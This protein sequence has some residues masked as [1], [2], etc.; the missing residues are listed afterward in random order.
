M[1]LSK[2]LGTDAKV[3]NILGL[4]VINCLRSNATSNLPEAIFERLKTSRA[5]L[6]FT[7]LQRLIELKS[8]DGTLKNI[9][10][11]AWDTLHAHETDV[12]LGLT[13]ESVDYFR[14]LLKIICLSLHA[15]APAMESSNADTPRDP[16]AYPSVIQQVLQVLGVVVARGFHSLTTMLHDDPTRVFPA[17]FALI[18]AILRISL[19]VPGILTHI[20]QLVIQFSDNQTARCACALLSWADKLAID[21]DPVYGEI[22]ISFLLELSSIQALAESLAVEGVLTH[23]SNANLINYLRHDKGIGPFD[24]PPRLYSIWSRGILPLLLNLLHAVGAP[25]AVEIATSLSNFAGQLARASRA[26]ESPSI[27][28][29]NPRA[30]AITLSTVSEAQTLAVITTVLNTFREAGPSVGINASEINEIGWDM[31]QVRDDIENLLQ[32]RSVLRDR[33]FPVN[34]RE[35]AWVRQPPLSTA[36]GAENRL[37]EKVVGELTTVLGILGGCGQ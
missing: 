11:T 5:D 26:F 23:I 4:T 32:R 17:D 27:V 29:T 16:S 30:G 35:E 28:S 3:Q 22:S 37:E 13:G 1:E 25:M 7:L 24:S 14:I 10:S 20:T 31:P 18:I 6:A 34:E 2:A 9:L 15:Y 33:I 8:S 21:N 12:G 36:G 19:Q